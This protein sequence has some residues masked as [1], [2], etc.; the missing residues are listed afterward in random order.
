[1][2]ITKDIQW[3]Q[4]EHDKLFHWDIYS[5]SKPAR[6]RHLIFHMAKY[7][8]KY[9]EAQYADNQVKM[10]EVVVDSFILLTSMANVL[11][12][13][14]QD[15]SAKVP[16]MSYNELVIETGRLCKTIEAWDHMEAINFRAEFVS[17]IEKLFRLW[18]LLPEADDVRWKD[19]LERLEF[20]ESKN[21][22]YRNILAKHPHLAPK[23]SIGADA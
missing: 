12:Y 6:L 5:L 7:Q 17:S 9:L 19:M 18:S 3:R 14:I 21:F 2:I 8:G 22:M 1:M 13:S 20:I 23:A 10:R 16:G 15:N 11:G 4:E